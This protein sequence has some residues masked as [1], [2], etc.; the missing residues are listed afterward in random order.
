M[1]KLDKFCPK[2]G[3]YV[4]N[5]SRSPNEMRAMVEKI[6]RFVPEIGD[7]ETAQW[8]LTFMQG[9]ISALTWGTGELDKSVLDIASMRIGKKNDKE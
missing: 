9:A 2:C 8:Y 1:R 5:G 3:H 4:G 6:K 7:A